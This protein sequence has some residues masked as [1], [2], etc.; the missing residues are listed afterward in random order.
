MRHVWRALAEL[1]AV[2]RG[3]PITSARQAKFVWALGS[4]RLGGAWRALRRL[5]DEIRTRNHSFRDERAGPCLGFGD[6]G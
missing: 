1:D 2:E 4:R 5:R 6:R 3:T